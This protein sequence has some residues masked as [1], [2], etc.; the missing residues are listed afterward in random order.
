MKNVRSAF[1]LVELLVVIS[2]IGMLMGLLLP[3]VQS[4]REQSRRT[5]CGNH[6]RNLTIALSSYDTSN[7]FYPGWREGMLIG[8]QSGTVSWVLSILPFMEESALYNALRDGKTTSVPS[9]S[10]LDCPSSTDR[11]IPRTTHYVVNC[12]AV[13]DFWQIDDPV[14]FDNNVFNGVFL[15]YTQ[16]KSRLGAGALSALDGASHTLL[17]SEN[18]NYGYWI[19][20]NSWSSD[21]TRGGEYSPTSDY[22]SHTM[23][24]S[25]GFCWAR[26]YKNDRYQEGVDGNIEYRPFY[27][28]CDLGDTSHNSARVPRRINRCVEENYTDDWYQS[29][30]PSSRHP[31]T[32]VVSY[33]DGRI[34][35][36]SESIENRVLVQ[37]MTGSDKKSDAREFIGDALLPNDL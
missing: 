30:R 14:T 36:L 28:E 20:H 22:G 31:G 29:A 5:S 32:V 27:P 23:E 34:S 4:A 13:D 16:V 35:T 7:R 17:M 3:A 26:K 37:L 24:G 15:D 1:T 10:L 9:L 6:Q 33:C 11:R 2:I 12:G 21:C 19:S 25:I 8:E 18:L